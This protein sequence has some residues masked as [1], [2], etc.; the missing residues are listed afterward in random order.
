MHIEAFRFSLDK[1]L[2][3]FVVYFFQNLKNTINEKKSSVN[4]ELNLFDLL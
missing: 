2:E 1:L 4:G 3:T